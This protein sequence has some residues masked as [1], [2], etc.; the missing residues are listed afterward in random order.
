MTLGLRLG[1]VPGVNPG[2]W[3]DT[4]RGRHRDLELQLVDLAAADAEAA[5]VRGDVDAAFLRLPLTAPELVRIPLWVEETVV[6]LSRE[7]E[8]TL[9]T[10]ID[11]ADLAAETLIIPADDVVVSGWAD[12]P[13]EAFVGRQPATT[14]DALDLVAH[15][16]GFCFLP[17]AIARQ[18]HRRDVVLRP[19]SPAAAEV[20]PTSGIGLAWL[21]V[22]GEPTETVEL[23]I[24]IVRGRSVNSNRGRSAAPPPAPAKRKKQPR[25]PSR[26]APL[27]RRR[28]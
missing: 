25:S 22:D 17:K 9:L 15:E 14:A 24:G 6:A 5:L 12:A 19:L 18:L 7:N 16:A 10:Q 13:G 1:V 21:P 20:T 26:S 2:R 23:W 8:L 27:R 4:W 28:R 11:L 3:V